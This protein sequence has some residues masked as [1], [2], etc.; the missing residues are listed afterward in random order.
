MGRLRRHCDL[1]PSGKN[2]NW[3]VWWSSTNGKHGIIFLYWPHGGV[4]F[5]ALVG[6]CTYQ[7][8]L[9]YERLS[10]MGKHIRLDFFLLCFI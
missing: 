9:T 10:L 3:T 1:L 5:V 7:P 2:T 6:Q 8:T 4:N